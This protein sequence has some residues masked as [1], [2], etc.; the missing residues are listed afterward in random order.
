MICD[1]IEAGALKI[2]G[3]FLDAKNDGECFLNVRKVY[4]L[5]RH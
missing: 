3:E 5:S 2:L 4:F 1:N